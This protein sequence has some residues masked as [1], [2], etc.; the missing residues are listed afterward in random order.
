M[1]I[2]SLALRNVFRHRVRSA[3][4]LSA[5]AFSAIVLMLAGGFIEWIFWAMREAA[6]ETG[7]GHVQI[8]RPGYLEGGTADPYRYLLP[9]DTQLV[10]SLETQPHV[11][12]IARRLNFSGLISA[13]EATLS[14]VGTGVEPAKEATI[15]KSLPI[16]SG[17]NLDDGDPKGVILGS[18]LADSLGVSV[19]QQVVLLVNSASG[20]VGAVEAT[21]RGIFSTQVKSFDDVALKVPYPMARRLMKTTGSHVLVV[22]LDDVEAADSTARLWSATYARDGLEFHAWSDLA[23]FYNKTVQLLSRQMGVVRFL[24][25]VIIVLGI[26]NMLVMNVL[27]RTGE[28]GTLMAM[29]AKRR[30]IVALFILEGLL[31]GVVGGGVGVIVAY[32]LAQIISTIGIPMPPPPGRSVGYSAG[33]RLNWTL[34]A[35]AYGIAVGTTLLASIYPS[36]KASRLAIVDA[37]RQNR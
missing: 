6:T 17:R 37:L 7:L 34:A 18:G 1:L 30:R 22:T 2:Y 35:W 29:G 14:F 28:I 9:N 32:L 36:W 19:G 13:G 31:I 25:S 27:E 12:A 5:I 20:N 24:I 33:I 3:V 11:K 4:A 23:D 16:L 15:S 21:V 26:S 10:S 8:M